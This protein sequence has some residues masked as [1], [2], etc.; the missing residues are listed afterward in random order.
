MCPSGCDGVTGELWLARVLPASVAVGEHVALTTPCVVVNPS[1][2]V[3]R[4]YLDCT[5][6]KTGMHGD[7]EAYRQTMKRGLD[8]RYW[9]EYVFEA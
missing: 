7:T 9:S 8:D 5:L 4:E 1:V 2:N 6:P 3:W